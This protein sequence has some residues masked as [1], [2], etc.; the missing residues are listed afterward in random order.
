MPQER[1]RWYS[2][3]LSAG[4]C[5]IRV[6]SITQRITGVTGKTGLASAEEPVDSGLS[7]RDSDLD[8]LEMPA[9]PLAAGGKSAGVRDVQ[10]EVLVR[11]DG[12]VVDADFIV[13]MRAS[14]SSA[15]ADITNDVATMNV[16][17]GGRG[18]A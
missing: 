9:L 14:R 4:G 5:L 2:D 7:C 15:R 10:A 3:H 11:I 8:P 18:E 13:E 12:R 6:R 1:Q 17:A 16:L